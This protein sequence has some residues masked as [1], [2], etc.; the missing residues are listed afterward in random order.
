M[1]IL[2]KK[3]KGSIIKHA[4]EYTEEQFELGN[5]GMVQLKAC[6]FATLTD[7]LKTK[8]VNRIESEK[9]MKECEDVWG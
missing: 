4:I 3:Q 1:K 7:S 6:F 2:T 9:F 5:I 8:R